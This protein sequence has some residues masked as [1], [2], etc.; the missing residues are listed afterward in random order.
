MKD[1]RVPE[2]GP[3]DVLRL[4]EVPAP[5]PGPGQ[6]LVRVRAA[7]VNPVDT[8][9]RSGAYAVKPALPYTPGA[10]AAGT[11]EAVGGDVRS[12][13][14][15]ARVYTAGTLT[16]AYAELALCNESQ[17]HPLPENVTFVQGAGVYIPYGTAYR[18]LFQR[19]RA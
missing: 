7:G 3:P 16:G 5:Q 8:Y 10:D 1:I 11:V 14:P 15:G 4:E 9:I 19:A 2:F 13:R 12:V 17:V 18:A 6:V